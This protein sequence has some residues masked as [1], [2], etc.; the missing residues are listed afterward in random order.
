MTVLKGESKWKRLNLKSIVNNNNTCFVS[1]SHVFG[2]LMHILTA[3]CWQQDVTVSGANS[4]LP[5]LP[6]RPFL[7]IWIQ[8]DWGIESCGVPFLYSHCFPHPWVPVEGSCLLLWPT[9]WDDSYT[10]LMLRPCSVG[11]KVSR[12]THLLVLGAGLAGF[13]LC[14]ILSEKDVGGGERVDF[15]LSLLVEGL[16]F[17]V[18]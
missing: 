14:V 10:L 16:M 4:P 17:P 13:S 2:S 5:C 9:K 15:L 8:K 1:Q 6:R 7:C 12:K 11:S 18:F 3:W